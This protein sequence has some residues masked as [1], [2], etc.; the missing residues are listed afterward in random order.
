MK[1]KFKTTALP[2]FLLVAFG[3][4]LLTAQDEISKDEID[5]LETRIALELNRFQTFF[6]SLLMK[7][8]KKRTYG[9]FFSK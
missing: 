7:L 6:N 4:L 9:T 8:L 1:L 2:A 5:N 3:G